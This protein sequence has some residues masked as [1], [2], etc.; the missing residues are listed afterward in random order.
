MTDKYLR[1]LT[2]GENAFLA[3][4]IFPRIPS[5]GSGD[6]VSVPVGLILF[7]KN[8]YRRKN[9]FPSTLYDEVLTKTPFSLQHLING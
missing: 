8:L 5:A 2:F 4:A 7:T 9:N 1:E 6:S 3:S